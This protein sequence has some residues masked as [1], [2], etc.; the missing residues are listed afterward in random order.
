[1]AANDLLVAGMMDF[2]GGQDASKIPDRIADNCYYSGINVS[3]Y[4]G[5][6]RPRWGF[7]RLE[8]IFPEDETFL[9]ASRYKRSYGEIFYSGKFQAIAPYNNGPDSYLIAVISGIIF[10]INLKTLKVEIL[11]IED[12]SYIDETKSRINWTAAG[13]YLVFFDFPNYPVIIDTGKARR[14][15]PDEKEIPISTMGVYN[16]NRLFI[17]NAGNEFTAG[18]PWGSTATP[19]APITFLELLTQGTSYYGQVFQIPTVNPNEPVT[20]MGFLQLTDTS[21]GIGPLL[22]ATRRG[23]YSYGTNQPR[24]QWEAGQFG[25]A[26]VYNSGVAGP[27]AMCNVNSDM[28]FISPDGQLRTVSMSRD[29]QRRWTK[30]PISREVENWFKVFES[31]L[32]QFSVVSYFKNKI[33]VTASPFR[34]KARTTDRLPIADYA[35]GGLAVL[36]T[37]NIATLGNTSPPTWAGIWTGFRPMDMLVNDERMFL[38]SK[39]RNFRNNIWEADPSIAHDVSGDKIRY[40][41]SRIYTKEHDFQDPFVNKAVH[42]INFNFDNIQGDFKIDVRYKPSHGPYFVPWRTYTHKAPWRTCAVPTVKEL[43]GFEGQHFRDFNLGAPESEACNPVTREYYRVFKKIQLELTLEGKYWEI[44]E[45]RIKAVELAQTE[46]ISMCTEYPKTEIT[47]EC[48]DD[49]YIGDF[50]SCQS[51]ET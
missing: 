10:S 39:D 43:Q 3:T 40:V 9:S 47:S 29:E 41:R 7:R 5:S 34:F 23:I 32:T 20:A 26:L 22:V 12:G 33:F 4:R 24:T 45:Y 51:Q 18:D 49:W 16:Q 14:A 50:E 13:K 21:T 17:A 46:Q 27:R 42:S 44:H 35:F 11:H 1:M 31:E 2:L 30:E 8:L 36:E 37:D 6:L 28:F 25:S 15:D 38:V 19:N 48:N